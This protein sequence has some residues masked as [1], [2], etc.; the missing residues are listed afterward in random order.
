MKVYCAVLLDLDFE[1]HIGHRLRARA[2]FIISRLD[3]DPFRTSKFEH[4]LISF[5][6]DGFGPGFL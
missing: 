6:Q 5:E 1:W 2:I 3:L 4:N